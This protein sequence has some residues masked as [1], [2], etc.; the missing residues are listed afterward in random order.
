[1]L[2]PA[3]PQ[4]VKAVAKYLE[5]CKVARTD[6]P[7]TVFDGIST[8]K[9]TQLYML[10]LEKL[11]KSIY[12]VGYSTAAKTLRENDQ[13]FAKLPEADQCRII[14]QILNLF[15]NTAASADLKL[16]N[17]KSGVGILL[18]SN[19]LPQSKPEDDYIQGIFQEL[20]H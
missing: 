10:L 7:I 15:A 3:W 6:L 2:S 11:E 20:L 5:R 17:G 4:Y 19:F 1:M 16:L 14:M 18:T 12:A 8:E 13:I 9:N